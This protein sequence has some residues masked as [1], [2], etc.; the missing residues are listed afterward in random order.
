M[1]NRQFHIKNNAGPCRGG[2]P[3]WKSNNNR[4]GLEIISAVVGYLCLLGVASAGTPWL[5]Q[6][7]LT[8]MDGA[9]YDYFGFSVSTSTDYAAVGTLRDDDNGANSGSVYIFERTETDWIEQ[10][11]LTASDG[12][13]NDNFGFAVSISGNYV[14]VGAPFNDENGNNSG[15]AY[16]FKQDGESW[17][18]QAKLIAS[19][20]KA[21]ELFGESVS[22][23]GDHAIVGARNADPN[24]L[25]SGAAYIFKRTGSNWFEQVKL[26][27][28]DGTAFD[29]FG[30]S[31][32]I[33][34]G[35]AI[36]G[37]PGD[38]DDGEDSGSTYIFKY[39]DPNWIEDA[40]LTSLDANVGDK[41]GFSVSISSDYA[42]IG[43]AFDDCHINSDA[44]SAYIFWQ[45]G[46]S[47][48]QQAK[49]VAC[50]GCIADHFGGSVSL[51]GDY[52]IVGA[53][54]NDDQGG[55][56][57]A[58]YMF[59]RDGTSWINEAKLTALDGEFYDRF[60]TSVSISNEFAIVGAAYD[61][62]YAICSGSVYMFRRT[63]PNPDISGDRFTDFMDFGLFAPQW[64][65]SGCGPVDWCDGADFNRSGNVNLRDLAILIEE[66]LQCI[67]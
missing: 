5:E 40:K 41:F 7:K 37:A 18:Q 6:N 38:D 67:E 8:A 34:D 56:S 55:Q 29:N 21:A 47:W 59:K 61:D 44:G 13:T 19:D 66:W 10:A 22:I 24:G 65:Q 12:S 51:D 43:A 4:S 2:S 49:L 54:Y 64:L 33:I 20:G 23:S 9:V 11:K 3:I 36:V 28:S 25:A 45:D 60:G 30:W 46:E 27:P 1:K 42:I 57:G 35:Y 50:D 58:A 32:D 31:V 14:I 26:F 52:A 16:I 39:S 53:E 48:T 62:D 63:G 15:S 17:V